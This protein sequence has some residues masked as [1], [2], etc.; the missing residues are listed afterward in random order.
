MTTWFRDGIYFANYIRDSPQYDWTPGY[1]RGV[2]KSYLEINK[3]KYAL[4]PGPNVDS[5]CKYGSTSVQWTFGAVPTA[6]VITEQLSAALQQ[7]TKKD[8]VKVVLVKEENNERK[9]ISTDIGWG[10][11]KGWQL[12]SETK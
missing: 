3:V 4:L 12:L 9:T 5:Y 7:A 2:T 11:I 10:T 1:L 6:F 8:K